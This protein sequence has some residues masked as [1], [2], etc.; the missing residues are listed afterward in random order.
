MKIGKKGILYGII[1]PENGKEQNIVKDPNLKLHFKI[2]NWDIEKIKINKS[3]NLV[4]KPIYWFSLSGISNQYSQGYPVKSS[5]II[6]ID[7]ELGIVETQNS[8]YELQYEDFK[9]RTNVDDE[10]NIYKKRT[11]IN[12]DN[13]IDHPEFATNHY[14]CDNW[15]ILL[16]QYEPLFDRIFTKNNKRYSFLGLIWSSDDLYFC[17]YEI[18]SDNK[19]D[20]ITCVTDLETAGYVLVD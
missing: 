1:H 14:S 3:D 20:L 5:K 9:D 8:I 19:M 6:K 17:L 4:E 13:L 11:S 15:K 2:W 10:K 16:H 18:G 7:F 12:N